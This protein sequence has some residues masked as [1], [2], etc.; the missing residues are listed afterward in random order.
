MSVIYDGVRGFLMPPTRLANLLFE[1]HRR[2]IYDFSHTLLSKERIF[3]NFSI[4]LFYKVNFYS[5]WY[6]LILDSSLYYNK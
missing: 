2:V 5:K 4:W 3:L 1:I 6:I